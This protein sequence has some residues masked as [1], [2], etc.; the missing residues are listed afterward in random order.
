MFLQCSC[1]NASL[2]CEY[3]SQSILYPQG[4][5]EQEIF[6][7]SFT[8]TLYAKYCSVTACAI[9]E[10]SMGKVWCWSGIRVLFSA[11]PQ[12]D[13][14]GLNQSTN[15]C[16]SSSTVVY[17]PNTLKM[18]FSLHGA[19]IKHCYLSWLLLLPIICLSEL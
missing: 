13:V 1:K 15:F 8:R 17:A 7:L 19:F 10:T 18:A 3:F 5:V 12:R 9:W 14:W 2:W 11:L 6:I 4:A 16:T